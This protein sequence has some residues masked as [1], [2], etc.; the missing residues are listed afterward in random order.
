MAPT[1]AR[2]W[3]WWLRRVAAARTRAASGGAAG[4]CRRP[5]QARASWARAAGLRAERGR[6]R[7]PARSPSGA[8][9]GGPS[10]RR[11]WALVPEIPKELTPATRSRGP[12]GHGRGAVGTR[13]ASPRSSRG[14]GWVKCRCCGMVSWASARVALRTPAIPAPASRWPMLVLTEAITQG[15]ARP[16]RPNSSRRVSTSIGSPSGVPVPWASMWSTASA[17]RSASARARRITSRWLRPLGA[18]RLVLRPSWLTALPRRMAQIRSR[19]RRASASRLSTTT[20]TP[21]PRA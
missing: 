13:R 7:S 17:V 5:S 12:R 18:V 6:T 10:D 11:T 1:T 21:S 19:S 3:A 15:A 2:R 4:S 14:L 16:G 20:P 9:A 8:G